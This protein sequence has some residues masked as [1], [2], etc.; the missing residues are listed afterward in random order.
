MPAC[1]TGEATGVPTSLVRTMDAPTVLKWMKVQRPGP[2]LLFF[3][4]FYLKCPPHS[5]VW[6]VWPSASYL[7]PVSVPDCFQRQPQWVLASCMLFATWP[8]YSTHVSSPSIWTW[9]GSMT[10]VNKL[11]TVG[12]MQCHLQLLCLHSGKK[13]KEIPA[14]L[15]DRGITCRSTGAPQLTASPRPYSWDKATWVLQPQPQGRLIP[16]G[17]EERAAPA[18]PCLDSWPSGRWPRKTTAVWSH[19]TWGWIAMQPMRNQSPHQTGILVAFCVTEGSGKLNKSIC[20]KHLVSA[21][22]KHSTNDSFP[23]PCL[24]FSLLFSR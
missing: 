24:L 12:M 23:Q 7:N 1:P 14:T 18:D 6:P 15:P 5:P 17:R 4:P 9:S 2:L 11:N 8:H 22:C 10:S 21:R 19:C 3:C 20:I 16:W 13:S